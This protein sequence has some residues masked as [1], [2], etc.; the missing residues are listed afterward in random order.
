M[1]P[2]RFVP[3]ALN[4][5]V[6]SAL[7]LG[8]ASIGKTKAPAAIAKLEPT[9]SSAVRGVVTFEQNGDH[10][11]VAAKMSGLKPD[12]EH[13]FHIHE[14]GDCSS[15]DGASAGGHF[16]PSGKAHG[17]P[18]AEHHHAG[19]LPALKADA[20]GNVDVRFEV[21]G[22]AI[23]NGTNNIVGKGVIVHA[24]PDDFKTQPT[25]NSGARVACGVIAAS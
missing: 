6:L 12:Q 22:L 2:N 19:D 7:C 16:N 5:I 25:G 8:C 18:G 23:G 4:V 20:K 1:Q 13:G 21:H 15:G 3:L 9:K 14:K 10:V 24:G 11:T 17:A